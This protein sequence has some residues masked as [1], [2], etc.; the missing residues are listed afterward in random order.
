MDVTEPVSSEAAHL[1]QMDCIIYAQSSFGKPKNP[2]EIAGIDT[3]LHSNSLAASRVLMTVEIN[4][5]SAT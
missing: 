1:A 2:E 4:K 3:L 5:F